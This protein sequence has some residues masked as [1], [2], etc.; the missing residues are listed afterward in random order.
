[1][2]ASAAGIDIRGTLRWLA[3][4]DLRREADV[5]AKARLV[6]LDTIACVVAGLRESEPAALAQL[7]AI[8][9]P[10]SAAWPGGPAMAPA[11]AAFVGAV[12]ACW[13]EAC[14]GLARA[15]GRPGL[16]AVPVAYALGRARRAPLGE[17]LE[18]IVWGYE[19]GGRAGEAMRI[20][21]GLHVDGTWG[22]LAAVAA[23]SR[24]M[25]LDPDRTHEALAM[26]ACQ[27]PA[28]L[29]APVA[30]GATARNTYAGHAALLAIPLAEAAAAGI[31]A[32]D[33]AF[34]L[35]ARAL[36]GEALSGEPTLRPW[37]PP[38]EFLILAGYLKPFA[39]VR[40]VH[41]GA[42]CAMARHAAR[43]GE[44]A[45]IRGLT[46]RTYPEALI[47][48]GNRAPTTPIQAQFSLTHGTAFALRTGGL[49]P[50]AYAAAAFADPERRRLEDLVVLEADAAMTGR[51]A[52]LTVSDANGE[53]T[54]TVASVPGDPDQPLS[55]DAVRAKAMAYMAPSLG[56]AGAAEVA[57]AILDGNLAQP[58][59][60]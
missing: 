22:L 33:R 43:G 26:A 56:M 12:A 32:P 30:A 20:R 13:H 39:A 60:P 8:T 21:A 34:D 57:D 11:P 2:S 53:E 51:G 29:Y 5:M 54:Y 17:I 9:A 48:C 38:G 23:A 10:G 1:M 52:Q 6:L 16:H 27:I 31:T 59:G 37:A 58:L 50:E 47:Y 40:H 36:A 45:T 19:I 15:H 55:P 14:E 25:G 18:A 7:R 35:A 41:Y 42:A 3:A 24:M 46:L 28:S 44:T 4:A 49:G